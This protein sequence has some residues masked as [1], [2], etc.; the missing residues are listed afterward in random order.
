VV[1]V[2]APGFEHPVQARIVFALPLVRRGLQPVEAFELVE[3]AIGGER[4]E[5]VAAD[6]LPVRCLV[7]AQRQALDE[8][9]AQDGGQPL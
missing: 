7:G 2:I 4:Q 1:A 6:M 8:V 9:L 5:H 3:H